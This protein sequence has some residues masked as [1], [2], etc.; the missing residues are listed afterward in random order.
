MEIRTAAVIGAG[1]IG[2][3][4]IAGLEERLGENLWVI[5]EGE[6]AERLAR[7]GIVVNDRRIPVHVRRPEEAAGADLVIVCVKYGA[8]QETLPMI[9][10][11]VR[12]HTVVMSTLNGVDSEE[13]IAGRIGEEH[14]IYSVMKLASRRIGNQ[15]RFNQAVTLGVF[16]GEKDGRRSDRVEAIA[17]LFEGTGVKYQ[18]REHIW[19]EIWYKYALNISKNIPQAILNLGFGAY[20][21]SEHVAAISDHMREEVVRV[22]AARGVD[23]SDPDN[24]AG[25]NTK[26]APETRFSTLQDLDAKRTTEIEMFCGTLVR[27]GKKLGVETPWNEFAYHAVKALEEKNSGKIR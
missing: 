23:I 24:P 27:M 9:E 20:T 7:D 19:Q 14:M 25:K 5:A 22:A 13:I 2:A 21:D 11:I 12:E 1:A 26:L 8:L 10:A 4:F 3:Y 16:F 17:E 15:I 18:I 6:R